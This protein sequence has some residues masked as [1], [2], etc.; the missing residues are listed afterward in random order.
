MAVQMINSPTSHFPQRVSM[1][2]KI[3]IATLVAFLAAGL[4][5]YYLYNKPHQSIADEKPAFNMEAS[6]LVAE[7]D[8][9]EEKANAKYLGKIIEVRGVIAEKSIDKKGKYNIT[10]QGA[11]LSG[12][13]CEFESNAKNKVSK[14]S[15][16][17]EVKIKGICTGVLM[18]VVLVDCVLD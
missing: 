7:Y 3:L 1:K 9:D 12:V 14:L 15:E 10:L 6:A 13:G 4:F 2:K 8:Q 17:Q 18:D 5:A 16:G 11:D